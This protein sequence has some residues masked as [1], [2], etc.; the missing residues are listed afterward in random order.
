[1]ADSSLQLKYWLD[2]DTTDTLFIDGFDPNDNCCVLNRGDANGDGTDATV[3]DLTYLIDYLFRGGDLV[4][5]TEEGN[6]NGDPNE[7][8]DVLDLTFLID[9]IFR[10]GPQ[11]GAC[12]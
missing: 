1:M 10:G 2:P 12:P 7:N 11:P 9:A 3:L 4:E 6:M 5:C 8:I